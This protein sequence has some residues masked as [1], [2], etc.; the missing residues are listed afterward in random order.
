[1]DRKEPEKNEQSV[2]PGGIV[3]ALEDD[4][5]HTRVLQGSS[6]IAPGEPT[7]LN[8]WGE[9]QELVAEV[10]RYRLLEKL[11]QGGMAAV[12]KAHDPDI[13]R[14]IAIKFLHTYLCRDEQYRR[15]F[16]RE[17][18]LAGGLSH[19]NIVTV[20]DVGEIEGRPYIAMELLDGTPLSELLV[21]G[22]RPEI[23]E[24]VEMGIQLASAL[25]YAH[26]K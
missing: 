2:L 22:S 25:D 13:D 5:E 4:E 23:R 17:A 6:R 20:Y 15:R 19:P 24:I 10:G 18:K 7:T 1:M 8:R 11:G 3:C 14:P 21:P 26:A 9:Q 16:M 12:Y